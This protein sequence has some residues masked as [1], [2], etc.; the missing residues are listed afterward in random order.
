MTE[1]QTEPSCPRMRAVM[2]A[3]P[4]LPYQERIAALPCSMSASLVSVTAVARIIG[5]DRHVALAAGNL[6]RRFVLGYLTRDK[7]HRYAILLGA[8]QAQTQGIVP[9]RLMTNTTGQ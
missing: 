1:W 5:D 4:S 2:F 7:G 8:R 6:A 9:D 3:R